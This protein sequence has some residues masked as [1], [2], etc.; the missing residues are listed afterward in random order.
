M[1]NTY[2]LSYLPII[3]ILLFSLYF[4]V[5]GAVQLDNH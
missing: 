3:S 5:Y 1:K 4:A 2:S